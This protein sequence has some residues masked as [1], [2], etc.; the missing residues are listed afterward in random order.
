VKTERVDFQQR[1]GFAD[2]KSWSSFNT[3]AV[4]Y[5][6]TSWLS[7][8]AFQPYNAKAQ[9]GL[10][11]SAGLGD[12]NLMLAASLK[13]D[14][15]LRLTPSRE[16]LDELADWHLGLWLSGTLPTGVTTNR[17]AL[18][19]PFAPDMQLGFRGPSL[20]AGLTTLKQLAPDWT[21]LSEVSHL[22]FFD[23]RYLAAGLRY[24][25]GAETRVGGAAVFR[26]AA[27]AGR[28]IDLVGELGLLDLQPDRSDG[29]GGAMAALRASGGDVLYAALG[30][31]ATLGAV[32]IGLEVKRAI[33]T[34]LHEGALQQGSEGL[35][36]YRAFLTVGWAT[37]V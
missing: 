16:S 3:L 34:A 4:G 35:E 9:H 32:S 5:G 2:Q 14:E 7:L 36:R 1:A 33:A 37:R 18:G 26:V 22:R 15:G 30:T 19:A 10:G 23:Q 13:W 20:G 11:T 25:F 21:V 27:A 29:A 17:D 8:F 28:R 12:T 31:R 6:L 24:Q